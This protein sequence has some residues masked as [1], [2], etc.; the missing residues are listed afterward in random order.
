MKKF[1]FSMEKI[2]DLREYEEK[3]AQIELGKAIAD[4]E[5]IRQQLNFVAIEKA[6]MLSMD[7][8]GTSINERLVHENY[9]VRLDR[10]KEILLEELA[11]AELIVEE[12]RAVFAEALK[13]RKVL[14]NLKEKQLQQYKKEKQLEEDNIVD[15]IVTSRFKSK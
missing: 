6:K 4:A 8:S 9:L 7:I 11:A 13:K 5:K 14:S 3:Q 2:L 15:D 10:Q 1:V 12:K